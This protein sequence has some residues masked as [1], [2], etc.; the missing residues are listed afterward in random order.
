MASLEVLNPTNEVI[1]TLEY[2]S[3]TTTKQQIEKAHKAF[4]SWREVDAHE[5]ADKLYKWFSLINEH[6]DELAELITKEGGKPLKEAQ[7]E[8]DYA[9]SY[10]SWYAE[11]AK[12]IYGR[13]IPKYT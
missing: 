13:T 11:E 10:V 1:E 6:K 7:G 8:V 12:R 5:R 3:E 2:T 4:K 9:N